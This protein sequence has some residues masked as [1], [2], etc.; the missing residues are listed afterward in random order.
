MLRNLQKSSLTI[1]IVPW[2]HHLGRKLVTSLHSFLSEVFL[3]ESSANT[4]QC[5][6]KNHESFVFSM[7]IAQERRRIQGITETTE[8]QGWFRTN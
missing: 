7:V 4:E 8:R 1:I 6:S 2:A 3:Q 5:S